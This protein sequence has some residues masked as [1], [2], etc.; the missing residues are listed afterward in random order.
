MIR[1]RTVTFVILGISL[2]LAITSGAQINPG[3]PRVL[4]GFGAS[5]AGGDS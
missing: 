1:L 4:N 2:G 3:P 5:D